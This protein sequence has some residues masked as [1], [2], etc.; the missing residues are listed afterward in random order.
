MFDN[1]TIST[2][3]KSQCSFAA[4]AHALVTKRPGAV[5]AVLGRM[6]D[7]TRCFFPFYDFSS[8]CPNANCLAPEEA[9]AFPF[10]FVLNI[11]SESRPPGQFFSAF[12]TKNI[13]CA[14]HGSLPFSCDLFSF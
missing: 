3:S 6:H 4:R 10:V 1:C 14:T 11:I 5:I 9:V 8:S 7:G 13:V 12:F 2:P